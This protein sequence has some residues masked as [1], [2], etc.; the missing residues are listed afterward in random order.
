M[1]IHLVRVSQDVDLVDRCKVNASEM[2]RTCRIF[3][4]HVDSYANNKIR[5]IRTCEYYFQ[6]LPYG[7]ETWSLNKNIAK[8]FGSLISS[9]S[10]YCAGRR[11]MLHIRTLEVRPES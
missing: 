5:T 3:S 4:V 7:S 1:D 11:L 10:Q 2:R 6:L 8:R 9:S